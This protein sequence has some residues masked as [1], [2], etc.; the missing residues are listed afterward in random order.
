MDNIIKKVWM[1]LLL[2]GVVY[3][4]KYERLD[5]AY[6]IA[7]PWRMDSEGEQYRFNEINKIIDQNIGHVEYLLEVGCGEGHQTQHLSKVSN[8]VYGFDVSSKAIKRAKKICPDAKLFVDELFTFQTGIGQPK[9]NL[10]VACEVLYYIKDVSAAISKLNELGEYCLVSYF[11]G[12]IS[13]L[14]KYFESFSNIEK[15]LIQFNDTQWRILWW[16]SP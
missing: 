15:T 13:T 11:H 3:R 6:Q 14:D 5:A 8:N 2:M 1:K 9:F 7:N 4:N 10:V 12:E 16:K